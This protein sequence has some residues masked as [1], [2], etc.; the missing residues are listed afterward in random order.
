MQKLQCHQHTLCRLFVA[1]QC[2]CT[3]KLWME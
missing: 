1:A 3:V 2:D